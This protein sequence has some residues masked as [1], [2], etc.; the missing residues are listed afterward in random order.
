M[1]KQ[2]HFVSCSL[3]DLVNV[4]KACFFFYLFA[5]WHQWQR[6]FQSCSRCHESN[7]V[8]SRRDSDCLQDPG[9]H[10]SF[11]N[12]QKTSIFIILVGK[13]FPFAIFAKKKKRNWKGQILFQLYCSVTPRNILLKGWVLDFPFIN[14]RLWHYKNKG[15][16]MFVVLP[17]K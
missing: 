3:N 6:W 17:N 16:I 8:H 13:I 9:H 2:V 5:V 14:V 4:P 7:W 1:L 15:L 11:G 10:P 12:T